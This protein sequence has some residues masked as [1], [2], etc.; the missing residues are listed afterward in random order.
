MDNQKMEY[1]TGIEPAIIELQSIALPFW[2]RI[3]LKLFTIPKYFK[4]GAIFTQ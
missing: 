3:P 1:A 4:K 2:L